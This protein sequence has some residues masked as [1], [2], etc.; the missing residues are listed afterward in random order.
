MNLKVI[1]LSLVISTPVFADLDK[2]VE[3]AE[4]GKIKEGRLELIKIVEAADAGDAKAQLEFGIMWDEGYW[5]WQDTERAIKWYKKSAEQGF[6]QAQ[7][8]LGVVY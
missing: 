3:L 1:L 2:A 7:M 5:I 4:Q 6:V 8:M